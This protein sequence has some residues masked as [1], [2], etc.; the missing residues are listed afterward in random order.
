MANYHLCTELEPVTVALVNN[1]PDAAFLDTERQFRAVTSVPGAGRI[2]LELYTIKEIPRSE[3]IASVIESRYRG[4]DELW[5]HP[6]DALIVTGTEPTQPDMRREP[7][8]PHL[9]R[10]LEWAAASV[11]TTLLSCLA[12]H[13][14][15]LLFDGIERVPRLFKCSGVFDGAVSEP[16]DRLAVGLPQV[17]SFPHSRVNEVPESCLID[18][19]YRVIIGSEPSGAGWTVAARELGQSLFVLCQGHPEY[20]AL[21]LLREYRRDVRRWL[22][23][24]DAKGG[25]GSNRVMATYPRVPDGYLGPRAVQQLHEFER[26]A[27]T[28]D[29]DPSVL[30]ASFPYH[31]VAATVKRTWAASAASI[32]ANWLWLAQA[33]VPVWV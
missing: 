22:F 25:I 29:T 3:R 28:R 26:R 8:W 17:V 20:D 19:G 7:H 30:W 4:L 24:C 16:L 14:A 31:E 11:P 12:A 23:G 33:P 2:S 32:Y 1:M 27:T 15:L 18:A 21:S 6:P 5:H 9:A 10:L 13:A